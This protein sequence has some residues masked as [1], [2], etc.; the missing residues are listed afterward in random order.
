M[1]HC[2]TISM[3]D[4]HLYDKVEKTRNF[5]FN[6]ISTF[7]NK[8]LGQYD[9][10]LRDFIRRIDIFADPLLKDLAA[11]S[12]GLIVCQQLPSCREEIRRHPELYTPVVHR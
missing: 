6:S 4:R 1:A 11:Q 10:V 8:R 5:S 3:Y 12:T 7:S 2:G 9:A